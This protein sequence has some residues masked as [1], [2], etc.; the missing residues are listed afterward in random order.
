MT[1]FTSSFIPNY[2]NRMNTGESFSTLRKSL[3][4]DKPVAGNAPKHDAYRE[5]WARIRLAKENGFFLEAITIQESIISDRLISYF[6][7]PTATNPISSGNNGQWSSLNQ[8]IQRWKSEYPDGLRTNRYEN[9]I[10]ALD[11]WRILRNKAIHAI[12]K[13]ESNDEARTVDEFLN[14]AREA[15][16]EGEILAKEICNWCRKAKKEGND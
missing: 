12:V 5:A 8:L 1:S 6:T 13:F 9:L 2:F 16:V 15:A 7:R 11:Q 10:Q 14:K 4:P 3:P